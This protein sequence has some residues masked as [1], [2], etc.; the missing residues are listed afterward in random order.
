MKQVCGIWFPDS[1]THFEDHLKNGPLFHE[2]WKRHP[3]HIYYDV[4]NQGNVRRNKPSKGTVPGRLLK[5]YKTK[6]GYL[7]VNLSID[8]VISRK[9]VHVLVLETFVTER[10]GNQEARHLDDNKSNNYLDNLAWGNHSDNYQDRVNNGGGNHGSRHGQS[11][12]SE[13]DIFAIRSL[14]THMTQQDIASLYGMSRS[15]IGHIISKKRWRHI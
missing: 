5:P 6:Q 3:T 15:A 12:L 4:S 2:I 10:N 11:K 14:A 1:D 7:V 9:F 8:G 13:N